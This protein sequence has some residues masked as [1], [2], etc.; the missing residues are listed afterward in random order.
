MLDHETY[1]TNVGPLLELCWSFILKTSNNFRENQIF[2]SELFKTHLKDL[3]L[4]IENLLS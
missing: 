2:E 4:N 3:M 1:R